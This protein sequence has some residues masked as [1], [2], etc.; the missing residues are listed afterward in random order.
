[1]LEDILSGRWKDVGEKLKKNIALSLLLFTKKKL[2]E[3]FGQAIKEIRKTGKE[4][5][6]R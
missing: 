1:M 6:V 2:N 4:K 3:G 5:R